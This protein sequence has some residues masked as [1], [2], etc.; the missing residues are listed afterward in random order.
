MSSNVFECDVDNKHYWIISVGLG[1]SIAMRLLDVARSEGR[2]PMSLSNLADEI[3]DACGQWC[4]ENCSGNYQL[5]P[6]YRLEIW[7]D[8]PSDAML[9]KLTHG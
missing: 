2:C 4:F 7:F 6:T 8:D 5:D 1:S 9:F 3:L